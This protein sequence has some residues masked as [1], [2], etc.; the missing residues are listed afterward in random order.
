MAV[1]AWAAN[2][3]LFD[4]S[5]YADKPGGMGATLD[6]F[7]PVFEVP[8]FWA[9]NTESARRQGLWRDLPENR[10]AATL[11]T[12]RLTALAANAAAFNGPVL[13]DIEH[14]AVA[15]PDGDRQFLDT[16]DLLRE[17]G[18]ADL[19]VGNYGLWPTAASPQAAAA[20]DFMVVS[21]Y[22][23]TALKSFDAWVE[24]IHARTNAALA[25]GKPIAFVVS[26]KDFDNAALHGPEQWDQ[27]LRELLAIRLILEQNGTDMGIF[28]WS[29]TTARYADEAAYVARLLEVFGPLSVESSG[30][31]DR[32]NPFGTPRTAQR[33]HTAIPEPASAGLLVAGLMLLAR[34]R[35]PVIG[36]ASRS[37]GGPGGTA[38]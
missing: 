38:D 26:P 20:V 37:R 28:L 27:M 32:Q 10:L 7:N 15:T 22:F 5:N 9:L 4:S 18:F 2:V 12:G 25:A 35:G 34:R 11:E 8:S 16:M 1:P 36:P 14:Y 30:N 13:L 31:Y 17:H 24:L 21:T 6:G 23:K 3:L 29:G 33:L 19:P